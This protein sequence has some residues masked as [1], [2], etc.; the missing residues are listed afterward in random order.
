MTKG[1]RTL[2]VFY[3]GAVPVYLGLHICTYVFQLTKAK[4]PLKNYGD[5]GTRGAVL[6]K[7]INACKMYGHSKI[8]TVANYKNNKQENGKKMH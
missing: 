1:Y 5:T 8:A 4:N 7:V 2:L 3:L 6:C